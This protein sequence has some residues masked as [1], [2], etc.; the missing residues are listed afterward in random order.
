VRRL[1]EEFRASERPGLHPTNEDPFAG[2]PGLHPTNEDPFAGTPGCGL[3]EVPRTTYRYK[4]C[5]DDGELRERLLAL[6]RE[7]P[8]FG[9]RR[10]HILLQR[11]AIKVN[12]KRVHRVYRDLGLTVKRT[13]RK[14]LERML[15]PRPVLTAPN[16]EWS[17][18]FASDVT[19]GS[20]RIRVLSVIDSFTKQNLALDVDTQL[21]QPARDPGCSTKRW[22]SSRS[23]LQFAV[24]TY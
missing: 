16:Q 2:T 14:R 9:Y 20:Q 11:E 6:A 19:A 1:R 17:I 5:R 10:L 24:T 3:M 21:P 13:R 12:H 15:Q 7:W 18:D 22:A 4:S 8:R 23:R